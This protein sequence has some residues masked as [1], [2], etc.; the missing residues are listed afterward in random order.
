MGRAIDENMLFEL[1][2][3]LLAQVVV[4]GRAWPCAN[5]SLSVGGFEEGPTGNKGIGGFLVRG[6][7]AKAMITIVR[8]SSEGGNDTPPPA[9]RR[10]VDEGGIQRFFGARQES[11]GDNGGDER[12]IAILDDDEQGVQEEN[13]FAPPPS[14]QNLPAGDDPSPRYSPPERGDAGDVA[15]PALDCFTCPRCN[16]AVATTEQAEHDDWHFAKD[17]QAEDRAS[18]ATPAHQPAKP[19]TQHKSKG[20]GR[21]P[22]NGLDRSEKGQRKLAFG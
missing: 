9:K 11:V 1:A 15:G 8:D 14:A 16:A 6:E 4:D 20:R 18:S 13:A 17:L 10:R 5:L 19:S 21:P 12:D 2:K 3:N 7:E 22:N